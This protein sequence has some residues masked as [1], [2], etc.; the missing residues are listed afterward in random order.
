MTNSDDLDLWE[1][2]QKRF[3]DVADLIGLEDDYREILSEPMNE[4]IVNFPVRLD[5]GRYRRFTGYRIQ[6]NNILGPYKGGLRFHPSVSLDESKGLA[7]LMTFKCSLCHIPFGGAKGG[8]TFDP[9]EFSAGERERIVRRFTHALGTNIG[10]ER[11]IPAPDV[12]SGAQEMV[13]MMDT[14]ASSAF[15]TDRSSASRVVTGKAVAVGGSLGREKATGQGVVFVAEHYLREQKRTLDGVTIGIQGFGN[16]GSHAARIFAAN[17]AIIR[18]VADHTGAIQN[19]DGLDS[20]ALTDWVAE[21]GGVAGF[22]GADALTD[23]EFWGA[24]VEM[25]VPAALERQITTKNAPL[26]RASVILEAANGPTTPSAEAMLLE[27]G[28]EVLP[29]ILVNAGGVVVSYFEWVQNKASEA[30]AITAVDQKLQGL[31]WAAAD[32]VFDAHKK[33]N[34]SRRDAAYAVALDRIREAYSL[35]GIFP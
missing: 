29:D 3:S 6:H 20:H 34:C 25:L 27:R 35:R 28:V 24:D 10:P 5:D 21:T 15:S 18:T 14:F 22:P 8:I 17:G 31:L 12:G 7:S 2:T 30:W 16:V 23:D 13:W 33:Y 26:I 32:R 9:R 11:D 1:A 4:I 19:T